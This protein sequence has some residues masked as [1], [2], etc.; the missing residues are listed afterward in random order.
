[1]AEIFKTRTTADWVEFSGKANTPIAP[2]NSLET[3]REDAQFQERMPWRS[4]KEYGTDLMPYPLRFLDES[5]PAPT[6]AAVE[7]G[8]N[9]EEVLRQVL[10]YDDAKVE[11]V[12]AAKALG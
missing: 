3:I 7:P 12:N 9:N 11:A 1:M 5:H 6:I 2:V 4:H 10:G 8:R